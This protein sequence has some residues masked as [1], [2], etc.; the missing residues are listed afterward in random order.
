MTKSFIRREKQIHFRYFDFFSRFPNMYSMIVCADDNL[1]CVYVPL[2]S[3]LKRYLETMGFKSMLQEFQIVCFCES[4][5]TQECMQQFSF[6]TTVQEISEIKTNLMV[7]GFL[8]NCLS[9]VVFEQC[10]LCENALITE[11]NLQNT[12]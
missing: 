7:P 11:H 8:F 6:P 5:Q 1:L 2:P 9:S 4:D 10:A 12:G 3:P